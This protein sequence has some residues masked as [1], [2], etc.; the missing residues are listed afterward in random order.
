[1]K[2]HITP[3]LLAVIKKGD[4]YLL[5]KRIEDIQDRQMEFHDLW[6]IPGGGLEFGENAENGLMRECREELNSSIK[7]VKLL[8][9]IYERVYKDRWHGL[10]LAFLCELTSP[11]SEIK[12]NQEA[13]EWAWFTKAEIRKLN[14]FPLID[15]VIAL[16]E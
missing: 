4:T 12:L 13:S 5:T 9:H 7:I 1:M 8:P 14:K 15:E 10:F 11:E 6:Q 2:K 3:V 16:V